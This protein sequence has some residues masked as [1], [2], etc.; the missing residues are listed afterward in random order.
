[1]KWS[2]RHYLLAFSMV[3]GLGSK[4][5]AALLHAFGSFSRAW[6]A[7]EEE[8]RQIPGFGDKL[9]AQIIAHRPSIDPFGE[10]D[11]LKQ[12]GIKFVTLADSDYP[13]MIRQILNPPPVLFYKGILP[14][15]A[16]IAIVGTRKP[17]SSGRQQAYF[18]AKKLAEAGLPVI[19]GLARG[20]DIE[21]HKGALSVTNGRTVAVLGSPLEQIYPWEHTKVAEKIVENQGCLITEFSPRD[22]IVPGN[23]PQRNRLISALGWGVLV[24]EAGLRSGAINTVNW[25]LDQ[26]KE[27]WAIPGDIFSSVRRGNHFLIKQGAM[28]VDEVE[29]IFNSL[30]A[31]AGIQSG[32]NSRSDVNSLRARIKTLLEQGSDPD[33]IAMITGASISEIHKEITLLQLEEI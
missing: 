14:N 23:F 18:F 31:Y 10:E 27:V 29:D 33:E 24:V 8:I 26:G 17:T 1:M 21:A 3:P 20:I 4:R 5:I 25:A 32:R 15:K 28:L 2:L 30:P 6:D 12:A 16:G 9:A 22:K 11:A 13:K 7:S 19:S